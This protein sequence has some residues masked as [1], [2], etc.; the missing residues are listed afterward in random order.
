M[1]LDHVF[2]SLWM[3]HD[4]WLRTSTVVERWYITSVRLRCGYRSSIY[5]Q[6]MTQQQWPTIEQQRLQDKLPSARLSVCQHQ[7]Y[8]IYALPCLCIYQPVYMLSGFRLHK[9]RP[10]PISLHGLIIS[11]LLI[12]SEYQRLIWRFKY[13]FSCDYRSQASQPVFR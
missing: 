2:R 7:H 12:L 11:S 9:N 3:M 13:Q 5:R 6:Q 1:V 10:T 8:S 4:F